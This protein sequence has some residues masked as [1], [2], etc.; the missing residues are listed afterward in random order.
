MDILDDMGVSKLSAIHF[1][2]FLSRQSSKFKNN[3]TFL[4][5]K[6]PSLNTHSWALFTFNFIFLDGLN[7]TGL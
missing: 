6:L 2:A 7:L 4:L 3:F 1:L 5:H